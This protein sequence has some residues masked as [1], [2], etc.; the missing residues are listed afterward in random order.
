MPKDKAPAVVPEGRRPEEF[1][2]DAQLADY[3]AAAL[4]DNPDDM[5]LR[6]SAR[7][8]RIAAALTEGA[9]DTPTS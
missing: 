9:S 8:S 1:M 7:A 3:H 5:E 6:R 4:A 2:N